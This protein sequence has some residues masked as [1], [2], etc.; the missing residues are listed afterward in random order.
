[1]TLM[2]LSSRI[3]LNMIASFFFELS[4]GLK[5]DGTILT[6][7]WFL[8]LLCRF[9]PGDVSGQSLCAEGATALAEAGIPPHIIQAIGRWSSKAFQIYICHH[10]TLLALLLCHHT[11]FCSQS[12]FPG[13]TSSTI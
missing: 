7:A 4:F 11:T 6:R 12:P 9:F 2:L 1:M 5:E 3:L 13:F 10:P 8:H